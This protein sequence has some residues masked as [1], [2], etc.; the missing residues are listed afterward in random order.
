MLRVP[1]SHRLQATARSSIAERH[2]QQSLAHDAAAQCDRPAEAGGEPAAEL[3]Q[4]Q[5]RAPQQVPQQLQQQRHP[6]ADSSHQPSAQ[7]APH[8]LGADAVQRYHIVV[9]TAKLHRGGRGAGSQTP[10]Q[11]Q[12][13]MHGTRGCGGQHK[14][15]LQ[16]AGWAG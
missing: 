4:D 15:D 8:S 9:R 13:Q 12:L 7:P 2:G 1:C 5:S 14:L 3:Q 6:F 16:D 10:A 11:L